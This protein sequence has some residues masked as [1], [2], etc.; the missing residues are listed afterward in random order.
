MTTAQ[1]REYFGDDAI[2]D[3]GRFV[4]DAMSDKF[5]NNKE[6]K[7]YFTGTMGRD[8]AHWNDKERDEN[9]MS[10]IIRSLHKDSGNDT[11]EVTKPVELSPRLAHAR[12]R[13]AQYTEDALSGQMARDLYDSANNPAEGFLERY[14]LK[15]GE[16]LANGHY[17][18]GDDS[19]TNSSKVASGQND[20]SVDAAEFAK[21]GKD[22]R[23]DY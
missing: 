23:K 14:K 13:V 3:E 6:L 17:L 1:L 7:N 2:S 16:R 5:L 11:P 8:E 15:L 21:T 22:N 10:A 20:V 18:E 9:D 19:S 12:A 4:D